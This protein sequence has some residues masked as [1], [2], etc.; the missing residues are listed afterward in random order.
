MNGKIAIALALL[1]VV[2]VGPKVRADVP[3]TQSTMTTDTNSPGEPAATE[4]AE[5]ASEEKY[6]EAINKRADDIITALAL[7]DPTQGPPVH[8]IIVAHYRN[9][10]TW[11]DTNDKPIAA[12]K[13]E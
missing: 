6:T 11:H 8:D 9:L 3:E 2:S 1:A 10:R 5:S 4:P 12:L 13:S 7:K